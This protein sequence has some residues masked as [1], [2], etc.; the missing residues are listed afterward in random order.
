MSALQ[1]VMEYT[2]YLIYRFSHKGFLSCL[3]NLDGGVGGGVY[4][5]P[6]KT[7]LDYVS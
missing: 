2:Q 7:L 4:L 5:S 1:D 3:W 6:L